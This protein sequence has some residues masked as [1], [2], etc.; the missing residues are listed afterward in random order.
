MVKRETRQ[1]F[2][3]ILEILRKEEVYIIER[4]AQDLNSNWR[5]INNYCLI[6]EDLGVIKLKIFNKKKFIILK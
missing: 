4:L 6:L 5:T 1:I 2:K 3:E